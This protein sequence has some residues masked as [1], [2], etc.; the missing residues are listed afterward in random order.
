MANGLTTLT[1]S[2]SHATIEN[3][4]ARSR[5]KCHET[6]TLNHGHIHPTHSKTVQTV[7]KDHPV[8]PLR[9]DTTFKHWAQGQRAAKHACSHESS[10]VINNI[11]K[12][13]QSTTGHTGRS[14]PLP[15]PPGPVTFFRGEWSWNIFCGHSLPSANSRRAVVSFWG[16]YMHN[17][18]LT[19]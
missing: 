9:S 19:T 8:T 5:C 11:P 2:H 12:T 17:Y 4:K 1:T 7:K 13:I 3:V 14:L 10:T 15:P 18:G 6:P 16:K